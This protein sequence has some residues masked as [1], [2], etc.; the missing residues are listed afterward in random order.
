MPGTSLPT[1]AA[2]AALADAELIGDMLDTWRTRRGKVAA[3]PWRREYARYHPG[4]EPW[5]VCLYEGSDGSLVRLEA[6]SD[7]QHADIVP[8][9]TGPLRIAEFPD[10]AALPGLGEVM[11]MLEHA[12]VVRYRPGQRCTLRGYADGAE[13]I[14][15]LIPGGERIYNEALALWA[16]HKRGALTFAVAEPYGWHAPTA[17]FWQGVVPGRSVAAE[18]FGPD[19]ERFAHRIGRALGELAAS[20]LTPALSTPATEHLVHIL[21]SI[22]RAELA[23]PVLA[24]RLERLSAAL[25]QRHAA[26]APRDTVPVHGAPNVHRWLVQGPRLGLVSFDRFALGDPEFDLTTLVA[27]LETEKALAR[28][29]AAM[30]AALIG[31][32]EATGVRVDPAR[33]AVY[34]I[35][36]RLMTMVRTAWAARPDAAQRASHHL[37]TAEVML[38]RA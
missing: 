3:Q 28:P 1:R 25:E 7:A 9:K 12:Q 22:A 4:Q 10:D 23:L 5:A 32:F 26:L 15:Q 16:A 38:E 31:G 14:V 27:E 37:Q 2:L 33:V 19:G 6:L 18:L 24:P 34:R 17:S 8:S 11:A 36:K 30:E 35:H 20:R 13:R 21:R 29:M